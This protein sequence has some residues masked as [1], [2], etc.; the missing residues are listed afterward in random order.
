M[1]AVPGVPPGTYLTARDDQLMMTVRDGRRALEEAG[2]T[3]FLALAAAVAA[4]LRGQF[5]GERSL[6]RIALAV[7]REL[8]SV[9]KAAA[10]K[11]RDCSWLE[12]TSIGALAAEQLD[13]EARTL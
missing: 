1:T 11:G 5:P 8:G 6:G 10:L 4:S 7:A 13:R 9:Q 2:D 12:V 3:E